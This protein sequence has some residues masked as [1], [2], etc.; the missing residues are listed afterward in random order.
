MHNHGD[1]GGGM[2]SMMWMM[3]ICCAALLFLIF[4]LGSGGKAIG[5][6]SWGVWVGIAA[7]VLAHVFMMGK[8]H[9]EPDRSDDNMA[10]TD[11]TSKEDQGK[12][13]KKKGGSGHG[14]CG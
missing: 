3:V 9:K 10:V 12:D 5:F 7:M 13:D 1:E 14:C 11:N 4:A 6:P 2:K 8:S